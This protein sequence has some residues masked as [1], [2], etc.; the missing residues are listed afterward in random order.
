MGME[1]KEIVGAAL[2]GLFFG[3]ALRVVGRWRLNRRFEVREL[4]IL[5][6]IVAL[7]AASVAWLYDR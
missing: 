4:F 2:A 6:T 5:T 1:V 3:E 7:W